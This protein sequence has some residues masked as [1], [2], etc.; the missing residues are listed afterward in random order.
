MYGR[1]FGLNCMETDLTLQIWSSH[2][3]DSGGG[4]VKYEVDTGVRPALQQAASVRAQAQKW[5]VIGW[6]H[7]FWHS[8]R[9]K[10]K[11]MWG[12]R[13][14]AISSQK[15]RVFGWYLKQS[16]VRVLP[17]FLNTGL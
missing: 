8:V 13:V 12:H 6:E 3:V 2:K 9:E 11:N 10:Y 17:S 1:P 7:D 4:A 14:R 16:I 5:G 15:S